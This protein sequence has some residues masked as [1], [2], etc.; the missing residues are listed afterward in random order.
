MAGGWI[1]GTQ[2]ARLL[3][4]RAG[5]VEAIEVSTGRIKRMRF[6]RVA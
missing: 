3:R 1:K 5:R 2:L 6:D 4:D